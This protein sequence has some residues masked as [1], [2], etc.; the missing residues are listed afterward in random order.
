MNASGST[1]Q[2][3]P[4]LSLKASSSGPRLRVHVLSV[5]LLGLIAFNV[6]RS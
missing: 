1:R 6:S 4:I 3:R 2:S 5:L